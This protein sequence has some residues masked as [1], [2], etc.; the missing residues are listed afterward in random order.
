MDTEAWTLLCHVSR[1]TL[2]YHAPPERIAPRIIISYSCSTYNPQEIDLVGLII[3]YTYGLPYPVCPVTLTPLLWVKWGLKLTLRSVANYDLVTFQ[4][5]ILTCK[6]DYN[7]PA[8]L[9]ASH[10]RSA[11]RASKE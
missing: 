1:E 2:R 10:L 11:T 7:L 5:A 4:R 9:A 6:H 8:G 3:P